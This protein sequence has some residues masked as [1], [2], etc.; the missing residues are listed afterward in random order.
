MP[1]RLTLRA[2]DRRAVSAA[3]PGARLYELVRA[4]G[5]P[6][7]SACKGE[8]ICARCGLR[9]PAGLALLSE[10]TAQEAKIKDDNRLDPAL[11]IACL[12]TVEAEAGELE[13][14]ADYW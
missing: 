5:W 13:L 11:V 12:R 8:G 6:L 14:S 2:G 4:A 10:E 3:A 1:V 7:G 9:V